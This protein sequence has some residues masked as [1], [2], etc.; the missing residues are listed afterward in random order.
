MS[1]SQESIRLE[2]NVPIKMRDGTLLLADIYRPDTKDKHPAILARLPYEKDI[3]FTNG[4]GY[5]NPIRFARAGYAVVFQDGRGTGAS[6]G[7]YYPQRTEPQDGYDTI[8]WLAAQPWCDGNVGMY[9]FSYLGFNQWAAAVTQ[10]PHLKTICPGEYP[11]IARGAPFF[12]DGVHRLHNLL[13]WCFGT[14]AR[15]LKKSKLPLEKKKLIQERLL[16]LIDTVESQCYFLPWKDVPAA[17][18]VEELGA[19]SFFSDNITYM[20]DDNY[21]KV[22]CSPVPIEKVIVPAF[23]MSGWYDV[24]PNWVLASYVAMRDRGGSPLARENQKVIIGPWI[25]GAAM[26]SAAGELDFGQH[27]TGAAVDLTGRHIRWFDYWLKCIKN[28]ITNE[29]P[30]RIFVMGDN[31]WRDEKE[32][33]LARTRYTK[34]YFCSEGHAN[35]RFG[36]GLLSD[37]PPD[38]D[39]T[40]IYLYNPKNPVPSKEGLGGI[41]AGAQNQLEV[42]G[43]PDVLVYTSEP[44]KTDVEVTGPIVIKLWAASS[45]VDTDFTGMLVDV[46]SNSKAYNLVEGIVRARYRE[47]LL[48]AKNIE[49]DKVYGYTINLGATSNVFKAGHRIRVHISS[50]NFPKYDRN[51]NTGHPLGRDAEIKVAVQTIYHNRHYPSHIL[52]PLIPR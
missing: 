13:N 3:L 40:D 10:P 48:D 42:E 39:L 21:W 7:E 16:H 4:T 5:M 28:G 32:W 15:V 52:L 26:L 30:V 22:L 51:L 36:D 50:S 8:E 14:S 19:P 35:S 43:R 1:F 6:E 12:I 17:K 27:S 33:P 41:P 31:V 37:K 29:P 18:L 24:T 44:L 47:S 23:H 38:G 9:G 2:V 25:H 20:D 45:A 46:W 34:F 49:P 11:A